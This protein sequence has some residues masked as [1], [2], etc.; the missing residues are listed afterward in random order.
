MK[1]LIQIIVFILVTYPI[2]GAISW[3]VGAIMYKINYR[4]KQKSWN[5]IDEGAEFPFISILVAAHNEEYVIGDTLEYLLNN[6]DY[7]KY[8]ILVINDGSTDG[9][10]KILKKYSKLYEKLRIIN[11]VHNQGKAN[12]LN[13]GLGFSK[14]KYIVT[15][16]ADTIPS[17][18]A[19]RRYANYLNKSY[20]DYI[21]AI[22]ANMDV[23][24]RTKLIAKS[25]TVEFSSIVGIIKRTQS[26][27]MGGIYA[28]SGANT[29]YRKEALIDVGLFRHDR[30][31]E[32]I[33]VAWDHQ[34]NGWFSVFAP[35]I[36]FFM[37]VPENIIDLYKQRKRWAKGGTEVWLTNGLKVV[38]KPFNNFGLTT[39][40]ID[41]TLSIVWSLFFFGSF[42]FFLFKCFQDFFLRDWHN[43]YMTITVTMIFICFEFIAGLIQVLTALII[44]HDAEK[45]KYFFFSPLYLIFYWLVNAVTIVVTLIP[46]IKTIQGYGSGVW[47]SPKRIK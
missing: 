14:A 30:A 41:Q 45:L 17:R 20:S 6:I 1:T 44:D 25:Q 35:A 21:S 15:N 47:I 8:E 11:L 9:T 13:I 4:L 31:T 42:F 37:Q 28:Y 3:V 23:Q 5:D 29:L 32:D 18:D 40:F 10:L 36:T 26:A 34:I 24:N 39:M 12:A 46:A 33:S 19:L 7:P 43:L 16:D 27:I 38:K 22:T 2:L